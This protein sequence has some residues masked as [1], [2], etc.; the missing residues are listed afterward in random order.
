MVEVRVKVGD[1]LRVNN[2][3]FMAFEFISFKKFSDFLNFLTSKGLLN[4][5]FLVSSDQL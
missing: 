5:L 4:N 1:K 2:S 3:Q